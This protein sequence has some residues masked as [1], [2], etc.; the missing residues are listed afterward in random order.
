MDPLGTRNDEDPAKPTQQTRLV[1]FV[2]HSFSVFRA[3][4]QSFSDT[5]PF[6]FPA[7]KP[8]KNLDFPQHKGR[9]RWPGREALL[10]WQGGIVGQNR[11]GLLAF[12]EFVGELPECVREPLI[13]GQER[14]GTSLPRA[15]GCGWRKREGLLA[16]REIVFRF[17]ETKDP[18]RIRKNLH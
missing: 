12:G 16:F 15:T 13:K 11:E 17:P 7:F 8:M 5:F 9:D 6:P 18:G 3:I 4:A 2:S 10:A 1:A 14:S